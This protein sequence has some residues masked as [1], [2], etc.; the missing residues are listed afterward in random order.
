MLAKKAVQNPDTLKPRTS[1]ETNN[2]M[3]AFIIRM[4]NPNVISVSGSVNRI[5]SGRIIALANP[6]NSAETISDDLLSNVIPRKTWLVTHSESAMIAQ[7][8]TNGIT[9]CNMHVFY[10]EVNVRFY[11]ERRE[12]PM[13]FSGAIGKLLN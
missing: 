6:S 10:I 7:C 12:K 13:D 2:T 8:N 9:F 4:K 1:D 11:N 3:R 5:R